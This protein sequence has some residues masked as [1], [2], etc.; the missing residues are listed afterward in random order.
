MA[1]IVKTQILSN[2]RSGFDAFK[3]A[4][5]EIRWVEERAGSTWKHKVLIPPDSR[6]AYTFL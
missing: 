5:T 3:G 4:I 1:Q 2:A 6:H